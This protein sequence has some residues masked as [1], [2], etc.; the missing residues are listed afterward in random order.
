M[1]EPSGIRYPFK[2]NA[3][4]S[5]GKASGED[6]VKSNLVALVKSSV[7]SRVVRKKVGTVGYQLLF[8]SGIT[9][10][11]PAAENLILEAITEFEP[12]AVGVSIKIIEQVQDD[13]TNVIFGDISFVYKDTGNPAYLRITL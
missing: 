10:L 9:E 4:G 11:A 2:I 3:A 1:S 8:R 7:N 12:R 13:N 5:V 6:K